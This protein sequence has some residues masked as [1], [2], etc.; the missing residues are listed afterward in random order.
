MP[1]Q[2]TF[3]ASVHE[4]L[5]LSAHNIMKQATYVPLSQVGMEKEQGQGWQ[6]ELKLTSCAVLCTDPVSARNATALFAVYG[7]RGLLVLGEVCFEL[8]G[9]HGLGFGHESAEIVVVR[10]CRCR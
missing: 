4:R 9:R 8:G 3:P 7:L 2:D 10:G 5:A 1:M 6:P